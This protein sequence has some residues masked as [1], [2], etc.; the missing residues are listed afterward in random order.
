MQHTPCNMQQTTCNMHKRHATR[1]ST[2]H[3][4]QAKAQPIDFRLIALQ[5]ALRAPHGAVSGVKRSRPCGR[6]VSSLAMRADIHAR[7]M[8]IG[9]RARRCVCARACVF[10][11]SCASGTES[12]GCWAV[13]IKA[14]GN[15]P[16]TTMQHTT[17]Y[18]QCAPC[19]MQRATC[20]VQHA[21][22]NMQRA[23]C[24]V[25]HVGVQRATCSVQHAAC[26]VQHAACNMQRATCS[27]QHAACNMQRATCRRATCRRATCS[28][29]HAACNMQRATYRRATCRRATCRRLRAPS[30]A[31]CPLGHSADALAR[32]CV[33]AQTRKFFRCETLEGMELEDQAGNMLRAVRCTLHAARCMLHVGIAGAVLDPY[34]NRPAGVGP[35]RPPLAQE[36]K[37]PAALHTPS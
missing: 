2:T 16:Y 7:H 27:V 20:S 17:R 8:H 1:H 18:V 35:Q 34:R 21:A 31:G 3:A 28:V 6:I 10:V 36:S 25:Q 30:T 22:C 29:Q 37:G 23:T 15:M 26:N 19:N 33:R 13:T 14:T 9:I 32:A 24:S 5:I 4:R 11:V 12:H